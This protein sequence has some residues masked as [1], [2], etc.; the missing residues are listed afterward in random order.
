MSDKD[1]I[2]NSEEFN[3]DFQDFSNTVASIPNDAA[4]IPTSQFS[5]FEPAFEPGNGIFL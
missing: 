4:T 5:S 3:I 1:P 2:L